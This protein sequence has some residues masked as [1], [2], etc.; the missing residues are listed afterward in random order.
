MQEVLWR[1]YRAAKCEGVEVREENERVLCSALT[2]EASLCFPSHIF[3]FLFPQNVT[4]GKDLVHVAMRKYCRNRHVLCGKRE[5]L[6]QNIHENCIM[7]CSKLISGIKVE[8]VFWWNSETYTVHSEAFKDV[9]WFLNVTSQSAEPRG[10]SHDNS[11]C[12]NR[13][14]QL[15]VFCSLQAWFPQSLH[16]CESTCPLQKQ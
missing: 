10:D 5:I 11:K 1:P 2:S 14:S 13:L 3:S 9:L 4:C 6:N 8:N 16:K 15:W 12:E 7:C